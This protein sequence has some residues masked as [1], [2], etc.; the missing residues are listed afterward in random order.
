MAKYE[1]E[2]AKFI[3]VQYEAETLEEA[4]DIAAI[5]DDEQIEDGIIDDGYVIWNEPKSIN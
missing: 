3:K 1:V 5:M 4:K 2:Y